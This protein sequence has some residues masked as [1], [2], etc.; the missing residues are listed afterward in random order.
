MKTRSLHRAAFG[1][2]L[3]E[4]VISA[5]L[6]ALILVGAYL[7]LS[8]GLA[9]QRLLEARGEATQSARVAMALLAADLRSACPLSKDIQFVGMDRMLGEVEADN[10]DF[11]THNYRPRRVGEGDFCEVSYFVDEDHESGQL[12]LWRRRDPKLDEEIFAGGSREE[13]VRGVRGLKLE[14][15]AG[16]LWYDE[17]GDPRSRGKKADNSL[18]TKPNL[19]GMPDAVRI[20]L[21]VEPPSRTARRTQDAPEPAMV[22]QTVVR[23]NLAGVS[24][25]SAISGSA[26]EAAKP[27]VSAPEGGTP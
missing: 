3:I 7:C 19:T 2:T 22:F 20:T 4:V 8:S 24:F 6:M 1:F 15:Y 12:T 18:K 11:A 5:S 14:Y 25:G 27:A 9:S 17:W 13:I 21:S 26:N 16:F 10:L 23:L